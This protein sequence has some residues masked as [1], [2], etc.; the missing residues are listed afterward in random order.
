MKKEK[1]ISF[2]W[3]TFSTV[4]MAVG[5][6]FFKFPNN[7]TFGGVTGFA[8]LFAKFLPLSAS[9][10]SFW[11]NM[12]L[13]GVGFIFF[14]R[15]FGAKT[16]YT[17][18]LLSVMLSGLERIYPMARPFT[19]Q[20][21]LELCFA[22]ALPALG[23]AILF[24][25]GASSGGTDVIAMILKKY[26]SV[27]IGMA[28]LFTDIAAAAATCFIFDIQTGLYAFL[29]LTVKSFMVDGIIENIHLCKYFT[30]VCNDP[31]PICHFIIH[32]LNRSATKVEATG[33]FSGQAKH[34]IN[35]VLSRTE[36]VR[37]R[38]YIHRTQPS[39]FV[40][41]SNTSEIVGKG[42]HSI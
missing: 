22:I 36:A 2:F 15:K 27:N 18:V 19:D 41:I 32:D 28:L 35:T 21:M 5:V 38:N 8:V 7:F 12:I 33:A 6:Y 30:V 3:L 1:M 17:T 10:I 23:S 37:L 25:M 13:L 16:A 42:F 4:L 24:N 34:I 20:P 11:L 40:M 9:D 26:T 39:A 31:E 14:G 29:G